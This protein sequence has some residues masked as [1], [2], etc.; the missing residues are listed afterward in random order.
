M[1]VIEKD[2]NIA[3]FIH[4]KISHEKA[5]NRIMYHDDTCRTYQ[6]LIY[7]HVITRSNSLCDWFSQVGKSA[8]KMVIK[9]QHLLWTAGSYCGCLTI[10]PQYTSN[11][12]LANTSP[13]WK[14][15]HIRSCCCDTVWLLVVSGKSQILHHRV[16][17]LDQYVIGHHHFLEVYA[18]FVILLC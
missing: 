3:A 13:S 15:T 17:S 1:F 18:I 8:I 7:G 14:H 4:K 16:G 10:S 2:F 12:N 5:K 6:G 11:D 9:S